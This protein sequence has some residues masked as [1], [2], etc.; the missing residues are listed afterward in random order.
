M[1]N[2]QEIEKRWEAFWEKE[3]IYGFDKK[4]KAKVFSIDTP[5]PYISGRPH[6]GHFY[7]YTLFDV[8]A[9]FKRM[10]GFNVLLPIGFD[11]N[12]LPTERYVE[13]KYNVRSS[14]M[15]REEFIKLC[16][17]ET[18]ELEKQA[19][20]DFVRF[21]LGFDWNLF[22]STIGEKARKIAQ[23]SFIDLYKKGFIYRDEEPTLWCPQCKTAL[24]Q[25]DVEDKERTT[26]LNYIK[27][28][29]K[30]KEEKEIEIATTRPEL[31]AACVA[32]AVNPKDERSCWLRGKK[33]IV[34]LFNFEVP[35]ICDERV[36]MDFG[37]GIVMVC[38]FGDKTDIEMW[39]E[40][41]LDLRIILTEEGKLNELAKGYKGLYIEEARKKILEDLKRKKLLSKQEDLKQYVGVCWRCGTPV[42]FLL[43][44]QWKL[45]LL[46]FKEKFLEL[47][48]KIKWYPSFYVKRYE[49]WV[50]GLKWDWLISRQRHYGVAIPVWYC[51]KCGKP[52]IADEK[53]LPVDPVK[54]KPKKAC[55]CGSTEF[56]PEKDVLDT[57]FTSSLT[58]YIVS[59]FSPSAIPFSL[60]P[61]GYEIIRT[62]T[63]YTIVKAFFHFKKI[64]WKE[65]MINGMVLDEKGRAMHKSLGNVIKPL[66]MVKK[67]GSDALRF[68][69]CSVK[70]GEDVPFREKEVRAGQR[71][72]LKLFN[73]SKL[74][75]L[76]LK[77]KPKI[78]RMKDLEPFD[79]WLFSKLNSV[80]EKC[81]KALENYE[82]SKAK[83]EI[84]NFFWHTFCENYLEIVKR[85]LYSA[86]SK[87]EK[88]SALFTLYNSFL[89]VI[90]LF[91][92]IMPHITEEIYQ[93]IFKKY[94]KE[95]SLHLTEWP[96][97]DKKLSNKKIEKLG[98]EAIEIIV[99]VRKFKT[100]NQKSLKVP[101]TLSLEREK[102]KKLKPFLPDL[103]A[104]TN[105]K[106]IKEGKFSIA[107]A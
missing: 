90:K 96:K 60:R 58:P 14:S 4:R 57:W 67:Y 31:L 87:K 15:K 20:Q 92:P 61:Q 45:K 51:K 85:R 78:K 65:I 21:G 35:V 70:L 16:L 32:I 77:E 50:K 13:E 56:V 83:T 27:F 69:A 81:T 59:G 104:V 8:I 46:D 55:T 98:D 18:A 93:K 11:D 54:D 36:D 33:V 89:T 9:R 97:P 79:V 91:A 64:P 84:E 19:K 73:A 101:I 88:E 63:F 106:E 68:W 25:A 40:H 10:Q 53:E 94:E 2:I 47:G 39:K 74:L 22:Y 52:I 7:S 49:D 17:K 24:A 80:V 71:T 38:T 6:I 107:F 29:L 100:L 103:K 37:T 23:L 76:H 95:K 30:G 28:K 34:P 1:L 42:E 75:S 26:K 62:W 43:T 5:P 105:A 12:G 86:S 72:I 82:I 102:I 66:E 99:S 3:N 41:K 48:R 44:K